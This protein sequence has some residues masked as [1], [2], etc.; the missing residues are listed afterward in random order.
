M[1]KKTPQPPLPPDPYAVAGAQTGQNVNSAIAS[2][3]IGNV[4]QS[5]PYGSTSYNQTDTYKMTGADGKTYD[6]P[7]YTQTT[8][9]SPEQQNLYNQQTQIGSGMNNLA[10]SQIGR[11]TDHLGKPLD[12]SSLPERGTIPDSQKLA[13]SF[14]DA[15]SINREF[16]DAGQIQ[17]SIGAADYSEDRRRVEDAL[18][19]RL[20]P[21]LERDRASLENTLVNQGFQR[22]TEAFNT[23]MDSSNRAANDARMQTILAGGQEQ[24]R[25]AGLDLAKGSF[26]NT[27]QQQQYDQLLGRAGFGNTAQQQQYDQNYGRAAFGNTAMGQQFGMDL[28]RS[29]AMDAQRGGALQ[30][31]L[32]L[33][34]QPIN[35]ITALGSMGQV[36]L[37]QVNGYNAP[38]VGAADIGGYMYNNAAMANN[39][40]Q[41]QQQ[42]AAQKQAA[43][44]GAIGGL[45]GSAL[46]GGAS[47]KLGGLFKP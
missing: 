19:S 47:G 26:A 31:T 29:Q 34:N 42:T 41:T 24:S 46:Y 14:A 4:N 36:S 2:G 38:Q 16:G 13:T 35:E 1:G 23:E 10:L 39:Q 8:T 12:A 28:T 40:W 7:R 11:L 15:G 17:K 25:L 3:V 45:G 20:N 6:V 37:P 33:R 32:A 5:N 43:L 21:Q 30:E 22:G 18:Y 44:Y 9:L 27:A